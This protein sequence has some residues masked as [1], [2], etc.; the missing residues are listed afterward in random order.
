MRCVVLLLLLG[1]WWQA[2]LADCRPPAGA[3]A[4]RGELLRLVNETRRAGGLPVLSRSRRLD[5]AAQEQACDNAG[6]GRLDHRD[7]RGEP[8]DA[9]LARAGYRYRAAAENIAQGPKTAARAVDLWKSSA[10]HRRNMLGPRFAEAGTGLARGS[11][12]AFYWALVL[13]AGR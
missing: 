12:G 2:A 6:R 11:D 4:A 5:R 13:G 9:R 8:L 1:V 3:D 10:G 7:A